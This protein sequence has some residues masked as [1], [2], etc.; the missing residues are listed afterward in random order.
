[1]L[2][3]WAFKFEKWTVFAEGSMVMQTTYGQFCPVAKAS[4]VIA[5]RWTPLIVRELALGSHRFNDL[6]RGLPHISRSLLA[7]RLRQL[8]RAGVVE[9]RPEP[10]SHR[11]A[12]YLTPA[13]QELE[14]IITQLGVWGQRWANRDI[15]PD[16]LDPK[17]LTWDMRRRIYRNRLPNRRVSM[18]IDFTGAR[19]ESI[20]ML[21][22]PSEITVC[23]TDP[24]FDLDL[25]VTAD[26]VAFHRVWIGRLSLGAA[27]RD[28][29][30]TLQGMRDV[31]RA[32]PSWLAL[33][34]YADIPSAQG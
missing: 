23:L 24:G 26:T 12:Y 11:V 34:S 17:L 32:F 27:M 9:R 4:E 19:R 13:G 14:P 7:S 10:D 31:V 6:E 20:W 3:W 1:M 30:I 29:L 16:D 2:W 5:E 18:Q 15:G 22:E 8:E 33:S 21:L 25:L 28:G